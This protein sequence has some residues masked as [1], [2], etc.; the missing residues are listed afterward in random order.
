MAV[1][2]LGRDSRSQFIDD[3]RSGLTVSPK[4]LPP[5]WFYDDRGCELFEE[6]T[7]LPEYYQT[8]TERSILERHAREIMELV[9]PASLVELG[10][11]TC[12][13]SRVL[14]RAAKGMGSLWTFVPFDISE[15]TLRNS[16]TELS[17]EF[18]DLTVYCVTGEFDHHLSEIPRFGRQLIVF[19]GSTLGN[20]E[21]PEA[22]RFLGE[23]RRL[24]RPGDHFLIGVDLIKGEREL[25][26]AYDD[27]S[28]VTANFN[29]NLL[30]RINRDLDATFDVAAFAH[31]VRWNAPE[32]RI[33]M[34]LRS[35]ADQSVSIRS[36]GLTV[37]FGTGELMRTEVCTKYTRGIIEGML[38]QVGMTPVAWYTDSAD[39]FGL[40]L[41]R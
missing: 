29:L 28:G 11:G 38:Q 16:A 23:V 4:T 5:R 9:R 32:H 26:A 40:L 21:P 13:K 2:S 1:H 31:A 30:S 6:I 22:E 8:R 7:R 14:I 27:T 20:F 18:D 35:T 41:A 15:A 19:L 34:C 33:E 39:R 36:A 12:T 10:A 37:D 25:I 17:E 24:M 3:V